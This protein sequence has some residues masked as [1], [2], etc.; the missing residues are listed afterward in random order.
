MASS[1]PVDVVDTER[2]DYTAVSDNDIVVIPIDP[3]YRTDNS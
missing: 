1:R 3:E 2:E